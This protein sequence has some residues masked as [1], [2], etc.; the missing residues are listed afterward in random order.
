MKQNIQNKQKNNLYPGVFGSI[1]SKD[2]RIC[3]HGMFRLTTI[4]SNPSTIGSQYS[5]FLE[6][7]KN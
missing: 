6:N 4:C 1:S 3:T 2:K 5:S 7:D